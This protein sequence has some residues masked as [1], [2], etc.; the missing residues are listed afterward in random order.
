MIDEE[1]IVNLIANQISTFFGDYPNYDF[2]IT[3]ELQ[4]VKDKKF[5]NELKNNPNAIFI[6]V[7]FFKATLNFGQ[8]LQPIT[9]NALGEMNKLDVC[10]EILTRY[11]ETYNLYLTPDNQIR[12]YFTSPEVLSNFNEIGTGYRSL[13]ELDGTFQISENAINP[14]LLYLEKTE[15]V[16]GVSTPVWVDVPVI[17]FSPNFSVQLDT[18]AFANITDITKSASK[19]GTLTFNFTIYLVSSALV[20]KVLDIAFKRNTYNIESEFKFKFVFDNNADGLTTSDEI[21]F[22]LVDFTYEKQIGNLTIAS[23]TFTE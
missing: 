5:R 6:V 2:T 1:R 10:K 15:V 8:V 12:E 7:K 9:I 18:Q 19:V 16:N 11:A 14:K 23:L 3:S 13:I 17:T 22:K 4:F 20:N 21:A